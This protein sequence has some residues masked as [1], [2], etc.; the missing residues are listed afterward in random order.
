MVGDDAQGDVGLLALAVVRAGY[1][2]HL[3]GDVHDGVDVEQAGHV[4]ADAGQALESHAGVDVLLLQLGVVTLAVG[5]ELAEDVVPDLDVAVAVAA[6]GAVGLA[7][8][9]LLAAVIV[10]LAARAAG[11]GAVLPEVVLTAEA[12]DALG[13]DAY[14]VAPDGEGLVVVL[15]HAGVQAVGVYAHPVGA[16]EELPAPGDGLVL[17]VVAEGEV[18]QHLKEGAMARGLAD[19]VYVAGAHALLAS[20]DAAAGRLLLAG[21]VRLERRHAGVYKQKRRVVLRD[22]RK[23]RQAQVPLG[24][25]KA[26]KHLPELVKPESLHVSASNSL[27]ARFASTYNIRIFDFRQGGVNIGRPRARGVR[28]GGTPRGLLGRFLWPRPKK[29]SQTPKGKP[30]WVRMCAGEC[31]LLGG[32]T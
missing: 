12:E 3:V 24:F 11:A 14:L 20:A 6:D 4:L 29:A 13:R 27:Y 5:V 23:A 30:L 22:E 17:E 19:V 8:A 26:Q 32:S 1:L 9:V 25:K 28:G 7:T 15:E 10:D 18:A 31:V 21:E 16:G 2:A